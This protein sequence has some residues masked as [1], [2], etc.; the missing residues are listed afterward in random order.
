MSV[1]VLTFKKEKET[2]NTFKYME[3]EVPGQPSVIGALY[4]QR[5]AANGAETVK[6]TIEI[7]D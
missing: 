4:L 1:K 7:P 2:K 5:W 3:V 6:I